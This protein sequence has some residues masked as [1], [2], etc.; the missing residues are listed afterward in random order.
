MSLLQA[1]AGQALVSRA[2]VIPLLN[3]IKVRLL[4]CWMFL[5]SDLYSQTPTIRCPFLS[6]CGCCSLSVKVETRVAK[7]ALLPA[8]KAF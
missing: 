1:G 6:H 5:S 3:R 8:R 2:L 4:L 7:Q